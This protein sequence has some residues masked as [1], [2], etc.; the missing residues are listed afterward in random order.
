ME[1]RAV[2][3]EVPEQNTAGGTSDGRFLAPLGSEVV[4]LGLRNATIHQI[5]ERVDVDDLDQLTAVYEAVL[6]RLPGA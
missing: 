1:K 4:E 5:D 2:L 6:Q 3:G